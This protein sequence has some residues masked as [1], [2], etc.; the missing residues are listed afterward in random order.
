MA[1]GVMHVRSVLRFAMAEAEVVV[2]RARAPAR[3]D[4][5]FMVLNGNQR[6]YRKG[7]V[8]AYLVLQLLERVQSR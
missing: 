5:N 4:K 6:Q 7:R 3:G 8:D 1:P 2:K